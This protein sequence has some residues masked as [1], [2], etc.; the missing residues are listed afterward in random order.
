M[1]NNKC[2]ARL[3]LPGK[4][5]LPSRLDDPEAL[6]DIRRQYKV[7]ITSVKPNILDI[8]CDSI[9]RLQ[10]AIKAINWTIHEMRLSDD[11][12]AISFLL[13]EP[14][15]AFEG[16]IIKAELAS[17]P[18]FISK[19]GN[20]VDNTSAL[21]KHVSKM[22]TEFLDAV[23]TLT[24]LNKNLSMRIVFGHLKLKLKKKGSGNEL[25]KEDFVKLLDVY[26]SRGG[27]SLDPK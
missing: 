6:H 18:Y 14:T 26:S 2:K 13:Q 12:P 17:R 23:P 15:N 5:L 16:G 20:G 4:H 27:A 25:S 21:D 1:P 22:T 3:V 19:A 10:E 24:T 8:Q 11:H 7:Y 9:S